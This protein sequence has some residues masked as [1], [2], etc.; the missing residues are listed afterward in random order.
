M[1]VQVLCQGSAP[2]REPVEMNAAGTAAL[3]D[4]TVLLELWL[5]AIPEARA[6]KLLSA[7]VF[8]DHWAIGQ[9]YVLVQ[10]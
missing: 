8:Q 9:I 5:P 3:L 4:H 7:A 10:A 6:A 1:L 2:F